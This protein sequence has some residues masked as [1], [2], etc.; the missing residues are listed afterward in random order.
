[1]LY[2]AG[3]TGIR[4]LWVDPAGAIYAGT[5]GG[6]AAGT[7]SRS[8]SSS[9]SS[10]TSAGVYRIDAT[11]RVRQLLDLKGMVYALGQIG[12]AR[13]GQL[14]AGTGGEGIL[15]GV[16]QSGGS[17]RQLAKLDAEQ[18]LSL[19]SSDQGGLLI[20][21][22]N[23]GQLLRLE[24]E[25]RPAATLLSAPLDAKLLARFGSVVWWGNAPEGTQISV[26]LRSGNTAK[27]DETWSPWSAAQ[28]DPL[29]S[30][31]DCPPGRFLQYELTL[32][33]SNPKITPVLQSLSIRYRTA[34][35][36]PEL[37]KLTV[38]HVEESD[39]KKQLDKL[40]LAWEATDPNEDELE[41]TL[42]FR[43]PEWSTWITLAKELTGK[44]H[45][46][47]ITSV[48][49][50][51]YVV[52]VEA[53]DRRHNQSGEA[54]SATRVSEPFIVDHQGPRLKINLA[55][56]QPQP[57]RRTFEVSAEDALS[58]IVETSYSVDGGDWQRTF[59]VDGLFDASR[60][61]F[62]FQAAELSPGVHVLVV[63]ATDA[64]GYVGSADLVF[65]IP[66]K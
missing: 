57:D 54:L 30:D 48:P 23:P 27:P 4:T 40:K 19:L 44:E 12:L 61:Q 50:G 16:G 46:W 47:D 6:S 11:G 37:T 9:G 51:V 17:S 60:E 1:M 2:D 21:T 55:K 22:G 39:G 24:A 5:A 65:E 35:Q 25:Y 20:G 53:S 56:K 63:R 42:S 52:R 64:A 34:N 66:E 43:K 7:S 8:G 41:Y 62:R 18:I 33:T 45:E 58:P 31:A 32:R 26:R 59:P 15:Y 38:P 28:T 14:V 10:S 13:D 36:A 3:E 29:A 49:E